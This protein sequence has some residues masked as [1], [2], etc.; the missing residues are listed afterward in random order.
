MAKPGQ[1]IPLQF[2]PFH[3]TEFHYVR[4]G[5]F[6][7]PSFWS[8]TQGDTHM[9]LRED[10]IPHRHVRVDIQSQRLTAILAEK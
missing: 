8:Q 7:R 2:I 10:M 9:Q 3:C 1:E 5:D 4:V 6:S